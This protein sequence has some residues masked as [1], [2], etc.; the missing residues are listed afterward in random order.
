AGLEKLT[1]AT[2]NAG[3]Y[4]ALQLDGLTEKRTPVFAGGV[5]ILNAVFESLNLEHMA[6]SEGALR[7]GI[8]FELI[9]RTQKQDVRNETIADLQ[10]RYSVDTEHA[11]R[12]R[13]TVLDL[14]DRLHARATD[15]EQATLAG[16]RQLLSWAAE[17][18][19][20]G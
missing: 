19:E 14:Y 4:E 11:E 15:E 16:E 1:D 7:E 18:H 6:V 20:I 5:A 9:G 10:S 3:H 2:I 8:L 17:L 13:Q 12:I